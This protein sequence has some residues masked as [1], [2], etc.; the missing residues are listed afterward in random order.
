MENQN[1]KNL[2]IEAMNSEIKAK[3]FYNN[4]SDKAQSQAGKKFF[5]E[6]ANFEQNHYNKV[7]KIIETIDKGITIDSQ[8]SRSDQPEIKPE[9]EGEFEPNKDEIVEVINLAIEAEKNAQERYRKIAK[10]STDDKIKDIFD[11]LANE[12]RNHQRILENQ[13]YHISNKGTIIWE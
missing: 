10:I 2:L 13:F 1:L 12:E 11:N 4:A 5:K 3:E 7:K 9:V 6:L 8:D